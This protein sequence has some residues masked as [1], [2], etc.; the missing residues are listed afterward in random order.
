[1][2][3]VTIKK[4]ANKKRRIKKT[5]P[6]K[7]QALLEKEII[8]FINK[9]KATVVNQATR[10]SD[11]FEMSCF[12]HIVKF[13]ENNNYLPVI[14]NLQS[15][16]YRY[17]CSTSGVQSNFSHFL[18]TKKVGKKTYEFEIQ[19][20]L[21]IQSSHTPEIFT[22]PDIC[23]INRNKIKESTDHY[24]TKRRFCFIE[25]IDLITFCEVKQFNPYPELVFNFI[26]IVNELQKDIITNKAKAKLPI[27][28]A[29][30]LMV[31]GKANKQTQKIK[32][33][34]EERYCINIIYDIF[35]SG[36]ITFSKFGLE[37]LRVTGKL[38]IS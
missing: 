21:A 28:I 26:G 11:F 38:P 29:P 23:V 5:S 4:K 25:N 13:Y 20:N 24:E 36:A 19:H 16:K 35:N 32:E 22:T 2:P 9:F 6:F 1:M 37:E 10:M 3:I 12:N 34:L 30:S 31:S 17:K 27:H 15:N 8:E 33:K 18:V 14:E 7:E